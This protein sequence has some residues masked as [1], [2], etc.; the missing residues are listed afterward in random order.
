MFAV[1]RRSHT[2]GSWLIRT[3]TWGSEWSHAGV[4]D[5]VTN[6]VIEASAARGVVATPYD[7]FIAKSSASDMVWIDCPDDSK[8]IEYARAQIGKPYDWG[9]VFGIIAREPWASDNRWFCFELIEAALMAG[10]RQ[11]FRKNIH[12]ITGHLSYMAL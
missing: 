4:L 5:P 10:G 3:F 8:A 11:R 9:G 6:E 7:E 2:I 1:Y 12:R